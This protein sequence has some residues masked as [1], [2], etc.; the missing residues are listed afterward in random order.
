M[1]KRPLNLHISLKKENQ[2]KTR[3]TK[4]TILMSQSNDD[5]ERERLCR[6]GKE[7]KRILQ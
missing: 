6:R 4:R 3:T 5:E 1:N 7:N 2:P